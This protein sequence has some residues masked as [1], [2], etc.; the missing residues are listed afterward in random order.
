M[1]KFKRD[2]THK[3]QMNKKKKKD[4][5]QKEDDDSNLRPSYNIIV[6]QSFEDTP[7]DTLNKSMDHVL[8]RNCQRTPNL[9]PST[10]GRFPHEN[11]SLEHSNNE[12]ESMDF[13]KVPKRKM[14]EN[15]R[16]QG[17]R[18]KLERYKARLIPSLT[19]TNLNQ[20]LTIQS[21]ESLFD[22]QE[23]ANPYLSKD[24]IKEKSLVFPQ[25]IKGNMKSRNMAKFRTIKNKFTHSKGMQREKSL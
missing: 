22:V 23:P 25:K 14:K 15:T 16:Y 8:T 6:N 2:K 19:K 17:I 4:K 3:T 9:F 5:T 24:S 11:F 18:S 12:A 20:N 13:L 21:H 1:K 10:E 7:E